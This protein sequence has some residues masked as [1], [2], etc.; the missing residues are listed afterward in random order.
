MTVNRSIA[1][2][3]ASLL[4]AAP[5]SALAAGN[6]QNGQKVFKKC[7]ACH[8]LQPGKKKIGPSLHGV[9]GRTAGTAKGYKFSKAM[10][11]H[12]KSGAVWSAATLDSYLRAPRKTVPGTKMAFPGLKNERDR[13]DVIAYLQ[14]AAE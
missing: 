6:A 7:A 3:A 8:A 9:V 12:G 14:Q 10:A 13:A 2:L 5:G 11:S 1:L 4:L